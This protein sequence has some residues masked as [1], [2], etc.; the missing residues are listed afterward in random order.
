V[1][2]SCAYASLIAA[3]LAATSALAEDGK[4][5]AASPPG[6]VLVLPSRAPVGTEIDMSTIDVLVASAFQE[7]GF[8]VANGREVA[9][10][11]AGE[12]RAV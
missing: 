2:P 7:S 4:P 11:L 6:K 8:D 12:S 10:R 1:R 5:P 9:A 3:L